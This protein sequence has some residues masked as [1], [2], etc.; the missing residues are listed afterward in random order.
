[1]L[2]PGA[3][4]RAPLKGA[5]G[6]VATPELWMEGAMAARFLSGLKC[7]RPG[8][9]TAWGALCAALIL[10]FL[11]GGHTSHA[12][13]NH[14]LGCVPTLLDADGDCYDKLSD[15]D[16]TDAE[17]NPGASD[18]P[19]DGVDQNCDGVDGLAP[20]KEREPQR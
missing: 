1:M 15:C 3:P 13:P 6:G 17:I 9:V 8:R 19:G 14:G 4:P 2:I 11:T 18:L 7:E 16:D 10:C 12:H 20:S 5:A